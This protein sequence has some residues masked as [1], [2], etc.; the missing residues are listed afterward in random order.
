MEGRN[1]KSRAGSQ[2]MKQIIEDKNC[3]KYEE[4]KMKPERKSEWRI[5][6]NKSK[7]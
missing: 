6:A 2:Y 3:R 7:D 4:L 5:T 1:C